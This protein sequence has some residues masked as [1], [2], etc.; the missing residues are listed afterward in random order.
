MYLFNGGIFLLQKEMII[1][2]FEKTVIHGYSG[3]NVVYLQNNIVLNIL[4][5]CINEWGVFTK[6]GVGM[7]KPKYHWL[8]VK[9][10]FR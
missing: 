5:E 6:S 4:A 10:G 8:K 2:F 7:G 1:Y 9:N 3:T